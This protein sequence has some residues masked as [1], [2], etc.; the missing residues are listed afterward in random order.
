MKSSKCFFLILIALFISQIAYPIDTNAVRYFPLRVGNYWV[1]SVFGYVCCG[2]YRFSE[3][4]IDTL[5]TNGHKYFKVRTVYSN[6]YQ[7]YE[8]FLRVDSVEGNVRVYVTSNSCSWLTNEMSRDSLSARFRDSSMYECSYMQGFGV[9]CID[10]SSYITHCGLSRRIKRFL[11]TNYFEAWQTRTFAQ[12]IG[13]ISSHYQAVQNYT[14][15]NLIGFIINGVVC[16]DT[17]L[18]GIKK[19][20]S[21]IPENFSLYQNYPNPFNPV[22]RVRFSV[23]LN[24]GGERGLY[25]RLLI[26]DLLGREIAT[27]VNESLPPGTYEVEWDGTNYPSGVY[28]YTLSAESFKQTK[29]M[30]LIR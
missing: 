5:V 23:P 22:T 19:I 20:A 25:I 26:F 8:E 27:L 16:G 21:E 4:V 29:R 11:W 28:Y 9:R 7:P 14:D 24:K 3:R 10:D 18:T 30:V 13:F 1:Y 2:Y 17:T 12:D 6:N 15:I